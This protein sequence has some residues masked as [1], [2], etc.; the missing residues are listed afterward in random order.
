VRGFWEDAWTSFKAA[1]GPILAGAALVLSL[2]GPLYAPAAVFRISVIWLAVGGLLALTLLWTA[3]NMVVAARSN[4]N[5]HLPRTCHVMISEGRGP[6]A[7]A[8][9]ILVLE[10]S[11]LFGINILVTVYYSENLGLGRGEVFER[12]I[13]VGRVINVQE[14]GLIQILV[15]AEVPANA[16]LWQRIRNREPA[17]LAQL[18]VKPS[19]FFDP[20][21]IEVQFHE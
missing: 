16:E 19:I 18:V 12:A 2:L 6:G 10:Q 9:T 14:N 17:P 7:V 13:G 21:G 20:A 3:T 4:L 8:S 1:F 15:L 5:R 11:E